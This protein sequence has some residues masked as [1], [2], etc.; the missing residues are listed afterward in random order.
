MFQTTNQSLFY[1]AFRSVELL[2]LIHNTN[3][4]DK[5]PAPEKTFLTAEAQAA[6]RIFVAP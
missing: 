6:W 3:T 4:I 2:L 1:P 5:S